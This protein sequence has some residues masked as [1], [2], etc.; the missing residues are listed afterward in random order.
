M[1]DVRSFGMFGA[2][3]ERTMILLRVAFLGMAFPGVAPQADGLRERDFRLNDCLARDSPGETERFAREAGHA[4]ERGHRRHRESRRVAV[5]PR[6]A[7][8]PLSCV[9]TGT[10]ECEK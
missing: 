8:P 4:W 10:C 3:A 9:K 7:W 6:G 1:M 5:P 2:I